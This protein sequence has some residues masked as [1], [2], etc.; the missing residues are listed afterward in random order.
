MEEDDIIDFNID[1]KDDEDDISYTSNG[2]LEKEDE[3]EKKKISNKHKQK[4]NIQYRAKEEMEF[5]DEVYIPIDIPS[6]ER[7]KK[8][9]GLDSMKTG[10]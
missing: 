4:T 6:K 3:E 10:S 1:L 7:F 8:Y 9:R 2:N 5:Q